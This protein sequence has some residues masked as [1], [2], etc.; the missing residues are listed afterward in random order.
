MLK[1]QIIRYFFV[2][3]F[4]IKSN[5]LYS[6]PWF[7]VDNQIIQ[8]EIEQLRLCGVEV[9]ANSAFPLSI[10]YIDFALKNAKNIDSSEACQRILYAFKKELE[11]KLYS[12]KNVFGLQSKRP[13]IYFQDFGKRLT[14]DSHIYI[15]S[16][17]SGRNFAYNL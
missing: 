6:E 8:L 16:S 5:S 11:K 4:L 2:A 7:S 17:N 1:N 13:D 10:S 12:S 14:S 9:P 3:F 15:S